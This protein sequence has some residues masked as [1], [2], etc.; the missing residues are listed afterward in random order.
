MPTAF[1]AE[2]EQIILKFVWNYRRPWIAEA[3]LRENNKTG[4]ITIPDFK[5]YYEVVVI[6]TIWYWHKKR[7]IDQWNRTES[8]EINPCYIVNWSEYPMRKTW[9][10]LHQWSWEKWTA[11]CKRMKL[12]HVITTYTKINSKWTT[13]LNVRPET[14]NILEEGTNS[15][16]L[17]LAIVTFF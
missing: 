17:T 3:M 13:D 14:I 7:H 1:F 11:T 8:P 16:S 4:G 5:I 10:L 6:K 12:D 9:S 2:L 15:N